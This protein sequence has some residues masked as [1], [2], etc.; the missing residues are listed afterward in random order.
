VETVLPNKAGEAEIAKLPAPSRAIIYIHDKIP[1]VV[2]SSGKGDIFPTIF[3]LWRFPAMLPQVFVKHPFVTQYLVNGADLMLPGVDVSQGLPAFQKGDLLAVCVKGNPAPLAVGTAGMSSADAVTKAAAGLKGKLVEVLQVVGDFLWSEVGGKLVPN[4]GYLANAVVPLGAGA[5]A[6][7]GNAM[8][9]GDGSDGEEGAESAWGEDAPEGEAASGAAAA[10]AS[11]AAAA[12][13]AASELG[14]MSLGPGAQGDGGGEGTGG[15]VAGGPAAP[16]GPG[17]ASEDM[18]AQLEV[19]LLQALYKSVKDGELPMNSSVLWT[20]HMLPCRP[21]GS[22][23]DIKKSKHKKMSKFLGAYGG[24]AGLL[25][26]KEDKHSGDTIITGINRKHELLENFRPLRVADTAAGAEA[27]ASSAASTASGAG[28]APGA[29]SSGTGGPGGVSGELVVEEM[30]K[31]G[32]ELRPVFEALGLQ[33]DAL[34]TE[35]ELGEVGFAYVKHANLENSAPDAKT[36]VLDVILCDALF[37]GLVKKGEPFPS[38]LPKADLREALMRR[39]GA[40]CR[41]TR[42]GEQAVKKGSPPV[43]TVSAEKKQGHRITR[44]TGMEP[45]LVGAELMASECQKKFACSTTVNELPGKHQGKEVVI[46]G[47]VEGVVDFLSKQYGI[48]KK[49]FDSNVPVGK[50]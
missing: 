23:L 1:L 19:A 32:R 46:Q 49:Y 8:G 11:A 36:I 9:A 31:A 42:G 47:H 35:K 30:W 4:D 17:P 3:A 33:H 13:A 28:G 14:A 43:V 41:I 16:A 44:I 7:D 29:S 5:A 6:L 27:A 24:K 20:A 48:P 12:A 2:D 34:Y 38:T 39:C 25:T 22:T 21:V 40:Q 18:E 26:L 45:F 37:K 50:K 10:S 15:E